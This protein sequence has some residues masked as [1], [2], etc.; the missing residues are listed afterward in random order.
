MNRRKLLKSAAMAASL[1]QLNNI[2]AGTGKKVK[3]QKKLVILV[4]EMGFYDP[5][6]KPVND[7]LL[8]SPLLSILKNHHN[9]ITVFRNICLFNC[10][11]LD[12][13]QCKH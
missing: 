12:V 1:S 11:V 4:T 9:D 5:F 2:S 7:D 13:S 3:A 6:F 10:L 8:S